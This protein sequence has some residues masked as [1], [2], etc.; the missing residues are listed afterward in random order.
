MRYSN[1]IPAKPFRDQD[2][3]IAV[4]R[5]K[6]IPILLTCSTARELQGPVSFY[7]ETGNSIC[8]TKLSVWPHKQPDEGE[9][10]A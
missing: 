7:R 10:D 1:V 5:G 8:I 2:G 9:S 4:P 6:A 3:Y